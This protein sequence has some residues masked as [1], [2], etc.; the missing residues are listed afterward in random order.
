MIKP[1]QLSW[2]YPNSLFKLNHLTTELASVVGHIRGRWPEVQKNKLQKDIAYHIKQALAKLLWNQLSW[3][4]GMGGRGSHLEASG[5][6]ASPGFH[7]PH[8]DNSFPSSHH[9][10]DSPVSEWLIWLGWL[11]KRWCGVKYTSQAYT[12]MVFVQRP[13][14]AIERKLHYVFVHIFWLVKTW[15]LNSKLKIIYLRHSVNR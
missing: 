14:K 5:I 9:S 12:I 1:L 11:K 10:C 13:N 4:G 3:S 7:S 8:L 2:S 6:T 15:L